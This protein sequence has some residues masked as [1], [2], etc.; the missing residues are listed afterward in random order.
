[1]VNEYLSYFKG[2][3]EMKIKVRLFGR[4]KDVIGKKELE[5]IV[6]GNKIWHVINVLA[7]QH[8]AIEKDKKFIM[9]SKNNIY[10][11]LDD[12]ITEGDVI[13]ISPPVVSGG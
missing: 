2:T 3:I 9:V 7:K 10:T 5:F 8:L 4:Y 6:N 13:T 1:V 11:T 12:T